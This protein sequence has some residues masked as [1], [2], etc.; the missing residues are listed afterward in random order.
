MA[1]NTEEELHLEAALEAKT[2][3]DVENGRVV[4]T[5]NLKEVVEG[6]DLFS[7]PLLEVENGQLDSLAVS[8]A[9]SEVSLIDL[10]TDSNEKKKKKVLEEI[11]SDPYM[12][13]PM[14]RDEKTIDWASRNYVMVIMRGLP[15]SG[16]STTVKNESN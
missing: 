3:E 9:L 10:E 11:S 2:L 7:R 16:K 4:V 5:K 12:D 15:G 1:S 13:F 8:D 6:E 14:L